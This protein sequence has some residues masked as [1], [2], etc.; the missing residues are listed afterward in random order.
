MNTTTTA[1]AA[2]DIISNSPALAAEAKG[3]AMD[4]YDLDFMP[5]ITRALAFIRKGYAGGLEEFIRNS[6]PITSN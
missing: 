3:W 2:E 5:P 1:A 4:A 6:S